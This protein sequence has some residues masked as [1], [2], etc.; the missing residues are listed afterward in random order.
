MK[1]EKIKEII[2]GPI[3][4]GIL[5]IIIQ[6]LV[7]IKTEGEFFFLL[8]YHFVGIAGICSIIDGIIKIKKS[9]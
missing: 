2:N 1:K 4:A 8:G 9:K 5:L 7:G 6:L 3:G